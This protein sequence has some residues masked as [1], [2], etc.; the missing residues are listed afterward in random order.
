MDRFDEL[1][2][3]SSRDRFKPDQRKGQE[4]MT[5]KQRDVEAVNWQRRGCRSRR[6]TA[7]APEVAESVLELL[8]LTLTWR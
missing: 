4:G 8:V 1:F 5:A 2:Y 3:Q 6:P 7:S